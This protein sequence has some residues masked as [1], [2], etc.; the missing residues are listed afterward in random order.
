[1]MAFFSSHYS[2]AL[3]SVYTPH[4]AT[5]VAASPGAAGAGRGRRREKRRDII[6]QWSSTRDTKRYRKS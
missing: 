1:M 3:T 6:K 5:H 4:L 2:L